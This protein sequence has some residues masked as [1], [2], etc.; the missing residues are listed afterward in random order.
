MTSES[1][2][3]VNETCESKSTVSTVQATS[4]CNSL[5]RE[6]TPTARRAPRIEEAYD[7]P[8]ASADMTSCDPRVVLAVETT[9][10]T[11][12]VAM[13]ILLVRDLVKAS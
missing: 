4:P 11:N 8:C 12:L 3:V 6:P 10:S 13:E 2:V 7:P 1:S 9:P 5:E